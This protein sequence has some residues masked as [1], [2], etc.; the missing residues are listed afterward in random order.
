MKKKTVDVVSVIIALVIAVYAARNVGVEYLLRG[1]EEPVTLS[2]AEATYVEAVT[3]L[4]A[5]ED[6]PRIENQEQW[7]KQW[8]TSGVTIEPTD[9]ISTGV[10]SRHPWVPEYRHRTTR[11]TRSRSVPPVSNMKWDL[12]D[13]YAEYYILQLPDTSYVLAQMPPEDA[14]KLKIGKAVT[15]PIGRKTQVPSRAQDVLEELCAEYGVSADCAFYCIN[16]EWNESHELLMLFVRFVLGAI[17]CL[18]VAVNLMTVL[19]KLLG[20]EE[21]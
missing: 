15:L 14:K 6:I 17:V 16:D 13:E 10:G 1:T 18:V 9:I 4:P 8:E 12:L 19:Y 7:E 5:A 3:G 11:R 2:M 20:L 21:R